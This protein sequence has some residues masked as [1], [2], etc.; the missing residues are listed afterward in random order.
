MT[1]KEKLL[2]IQLKL[3]VPKNKE[4]KFGGF[5]YRSLEDIQA[6]LKDYE[7]AHKVLFTLTYD[8]RLVG[9]YVYI[10]ATVKAID[11][12]RD[13]VMEVS[14][15]ARDAIDKKGMDAPQVTGTAS[16]YAAKRA[17]AGLLNIDDEVDTDGLDNRQKNDNGSLIVKLSAMCEEKNIDVSDFCRTVYEGRT[18]NEC[19]GEQLR[20]AIDRFQ[21]AVGL[22]KKMKNA[23]S[24]EIPMP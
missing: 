3:N 9:D 10:V 23:A 18:P 2:D 22:Y 1:L 8:V 24:E 21:N 20:A 5:M 11:T 13:E 12:E 19:S 17:Y 4:N 15:P 6:A 16:S 14:A 7:E